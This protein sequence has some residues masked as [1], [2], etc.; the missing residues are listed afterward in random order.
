MS[1][2]EILSPEGLR[3]D[4][5]RPSE[6]R[7]LRCRLSAEPKADG[8]AYLEQGNTKVLVTVC[9]PHEVSSQRKAQHDRAVLHCTYSALP[10]AGGVHKSR[11][12]RVE[13]ELAAAVRSV[14]DPVV[15]TQ[16]YPRTQI[17]VSLM[18]LQADGGV[19]AACINAT[20]LALIDAGV[21]MEDFVCA[22]T[23]GAVQGALLLDMNAQEDGA[24]A[25]LTVG[26][27]PRSDRVSLLQLES[28]V[29]L[30][31]ADELVNFAIEGCRQVFEE[32]SG[33]VQLHSQEILAT[34]GVHVT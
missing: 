28:K 6:I 4:G 23:A 20:T 10:F 7:R 19:R 2:S 3:L 26:L 17:D 31:S 24:G 9:G 33:A 34:R 12:D 21:A 11:A 14:F 29:P 16:L 22:C 15:Q 13:R 30:A 1:R 32:L 5:R 8:S 27:L 25:E 18:L